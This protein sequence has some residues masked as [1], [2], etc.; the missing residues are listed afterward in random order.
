MKE[1]FTN[2]KK[3]SKENASADQLR[4]NKI[5]VSYQENLHRRSYLFKN[6]FL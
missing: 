5:Y 4:K 2:L 6:W 1:A 3:S